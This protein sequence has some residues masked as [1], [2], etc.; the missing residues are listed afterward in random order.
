MQPPVPSTFRTRL[1]DLNFIPRFTSSQRSSQLNQKNTTMTLRWGI[2]GPGRISYKFAHDLVHVERAQR[3]SQSV[4]AI[5]SNSNIANATSLAQK[6]GIDATCFGTYDALIE[7]DSCDVV[8]VGTPNNTHFDLACKVLHA[9]KHLLMEKPFALTVEETDKILELAAEKKLFV[10][11]AMWTKF[12]PVFTKCRELLESGVIGSVTRVRS[13][14]SYLFPRDDPGM[15]RIYDPAL[16]GGVLLDIGI[17]ALTW[18]L[19]LFGA[20]VSSTSKCVKADTGV[21]IADSV[22]LEYPG[23]VAYA[24]CSGL[25]NQVGTNTGTLTNPAIFIEGTLGYVSVNQADQPTKLVATTWEGTIIE[26][27]TYEPKG[28]GMSLEADHVLACVEASKIESPVHTWDDTKL[29]SRMLA[30]TLEEN[31]ILF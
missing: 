19:A 10:M 5:A 20:P 30:G 2:L 22:L 18:P 1:L 13:D 17:Y 24:T 28:F 15:V 11:E 3:A 4:T 7:S 29:M 6:L 31:G 25:T 27:F 8:Y 23:F 14:L 12:N 26:E 16:G 21:D 9:G